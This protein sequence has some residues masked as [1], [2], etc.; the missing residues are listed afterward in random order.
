MLQLAPRVERVRWHALVTALT[1]LAGGCTLLPPAEPRLS[2]PRDSG[3]AAPSEAPPDSS[4]T[5]AEASRSTAESGAG[6]A[7]P[8]VAAASP[9]TTMLLEQSRRER[10]A[11]SLDDAADSLERALRID[12]DNP[13]LWLELGE[14][15]MMVGD[16]AQAEEMARKAL[17]LAGSDQALV[18]RADRLLAAIRSR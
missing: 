7:A 5:G 11:G 13:W 3:T 15:H 8:P 18:G 2:L 12:P 6:P 17:S 10:A 4:A 16:S 9:A 14:I 1:L